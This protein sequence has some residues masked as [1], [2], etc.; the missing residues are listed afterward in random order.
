LKT[1]DPDKEIKVNSFAKFGRILLD[2]VPAWLDLDPAW[3]ISFSLRSLFAA[4]RPDW[5]FATRQ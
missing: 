5:P 1:F 2:A 3:G 4:T